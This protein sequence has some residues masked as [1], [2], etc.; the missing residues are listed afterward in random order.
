MTS[1]LRSNH[2]WT[3]VILLMTL[4]VPRCVMAMDMAA[5]QAVEHAMP[6]H[7]QANIDA[8]QIQINCA[9]QCEQS[10][11]SSTSVKESDPRFSSHSLVAIASTHIPVFSSLTS[12][13]LHQG[14]PPDNQFLLSS[15]PDLYLHTGRLRL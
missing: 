9:Q 15:T 10:L 13:T 14:W 6:C 8:Q 1:R 11:A 12:T 3:T 5:R 2:T 7:G 4:I